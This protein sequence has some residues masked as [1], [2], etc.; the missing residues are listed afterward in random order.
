MS[1]RAT[2]EKPF[3][4]SWKRQL[5]LSVPCLHFLGTWDAGMAIR[6]SECADWLP[7]GGGGV[8]DVGCCLPAVINVN[9]KRLELISS[10]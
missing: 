7:G 9:N 6:Q 10:S 8:G 5:S 2:G 4:A 1:D 3:L